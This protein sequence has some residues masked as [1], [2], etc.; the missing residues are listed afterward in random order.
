MYDRSTASASKWSLG[1]DGAVEP[2][3][4]VESP[5]I[6][7]KTDDVRIKSSK[8]RS[9]PPSQ[10][11]VDEALTTATTLVIAEMLNGLL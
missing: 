7:A 2:Y 8:S 1:R 11:C 9:L 5:G 4:E 3:G 6:N 10:A